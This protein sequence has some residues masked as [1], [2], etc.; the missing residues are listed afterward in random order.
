MED[1]LE[2]H[3]KFMP[4]HPLGRR[5]PTVQALLTALVKS[6]KVTH[7]GPVPVRDHDSPIHL[8]QIHDI[9]HDLRHHLKR[10]RSFTAR[11]QK[12]VASQRI[13]RQLGHERKFAGKALTL[14]PLCEGTSVLSQPTGGRH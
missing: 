3:R 1:A 12:G 4:D 2:V 9:A 8:Q 13:H 7:L 14:C 11:S 6:E 5:N 10:I